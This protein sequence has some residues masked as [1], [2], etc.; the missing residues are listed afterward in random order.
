MELRCRLQGLIPVTGKYCTWQSG[1]D[2]NVRTASANFSMRINFTLADFSTCTLMYYTVL[3]CLVLYCIIVYCNVLQF[4]TPALGTQGSLAGISRVS[5]EQW[6]L[7]SV[8]IYTVL[9]HPGLSGRELVVYFTCCLRVPNIMQICF[10]RAKKLSSL[11]TTTTTTNSI[12]GHT[13]QTRGKFNLKGAHYHT[14]VCHSIQETSRI[15]K[16]CVRIVAQIHY[17]YFFSGVSV[18]VRWHVSHVRC[19]V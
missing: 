17:Y 5:L 11:R 10:K 14:R 2:C 12:L 7:V 19:Q 18:S 8:C 13:S 16:T 3:Y 1:E 6:C 9:L 15:R 4:L